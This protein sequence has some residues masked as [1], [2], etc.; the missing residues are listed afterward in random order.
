MVKNPPANAG[1]TGSIPG[2]GG[3]HMPRSNWADV[4]QLSSWATTAE[5]VLWSP[6]ATAAEAHAPGAGATRRERPPQWEARAQ[7]QGMAPTRRSWGEP[8]HSNKDPMQP[9]INK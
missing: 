5:P 7:R 9:K 8:A 4:E 1:D 3:S 2:P 6:H